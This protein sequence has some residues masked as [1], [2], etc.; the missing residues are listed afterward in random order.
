VGRRVV[1]R[2][3]VGR[4]VVGRR[5]VGRRVV[6]GLEHTDLGFVRMPEGFT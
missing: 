5:V 4:R 1:G 3:V 6:V 2:R